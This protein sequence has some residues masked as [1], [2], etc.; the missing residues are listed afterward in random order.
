MTMSKSG[1][2]GPYA[3]NFDSINETVVKTSP[4]AFA[5][6]YV[7][8]AGKFCI[9]SVGRSDADLRERL[10]SVIGAGSL[11]KFRYCETAKAAFE[12]E[13]QLFHEFRPGGSPLHPAR[14]TGSK[15]T[16]PYCQALS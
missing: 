8:G 1:L 4:G 13:C 16:C 2:L 15:L 10:R 12:K 11:F 5:L 9:S 6:G 14:P 3:L 7:D